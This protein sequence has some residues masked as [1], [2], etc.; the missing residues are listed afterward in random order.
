MTGQTLVRRSEATVMD[1]AKHLAQWTEQSP[2][3]WLGAANRF[4]PAVVTLVLVLGIAYQLSSLTWTLLGASALGA[5][6][7]PIIASSPRGPVT[8]STTDFATLTGAHLFGEAPK[9]TAPVAAAAIDAPDTT[10]SLTLSG[11]LYSD[12]KLA[13]AIIG[14]ARGQEKSYAV[15]QAIDNANGATLHSVLADRVL[16]DRSGQLETLRLP[17]EPAGGGP[18]A[19]RAPMPLAPAA[20]ATVPNGSLRQVIT[21]NASRLT[22]VLR[23]APHVEEG[24]VVGFRVNPGRDRDTFEALGLKA[25]DVITDI[26]GTVLDDPSRGLQVFESLGEATTA[27]VT[28]LRDGTP[29]VL[30]VDTTQLQSLQENR[31]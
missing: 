18:A 21:Q 4:L 25:G 6:T 12:G 26:N 5:G 13:G 15:G 8:K 1:V 11:I 7:V 9:E 31:E 14:A 16:L 23:I 17:K 24:K 19:A 20:Q 10:L 28:V 22:D 3:Q 2:E 29:Q 27:N 30:V